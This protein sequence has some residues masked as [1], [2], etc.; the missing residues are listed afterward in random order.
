MRNVV[1]VVCSVGGRKRE[2]KQKHHRKK[3]NC[4]LFWKEKVRA[5]Q[6]VRESVKK[7]NNRFSVYFPL[8]LCSDF[9]ARTE[10]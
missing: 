5:S 9:N 2:S 3:E 7:E 10:Y 1:Y 4:M 8:D 6:E